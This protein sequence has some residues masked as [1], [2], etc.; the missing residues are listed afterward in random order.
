MF[1]K[2]FIKI[3]SRV[4]FHDP[5]ILLTF[6]KIEVFFLV[7]MQGI[8]DRGGLRVVLGDSRNLIDVYC[9]V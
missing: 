3:N 2:S 6:I 7:L 1:G 4:M 8:D 9:L 5:C